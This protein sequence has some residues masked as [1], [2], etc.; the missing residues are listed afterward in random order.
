MR[1]AQYG[2][3]QIARSSRS[4]GENLP[5]VVSF[6]PCVTGRPPSRQS[7]VKQAVEAS[8]AGLD[9]VLTLHEAL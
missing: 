5:H 6:P 8:E 7:Q 3:T 9:R 2:I 4:F 1:G